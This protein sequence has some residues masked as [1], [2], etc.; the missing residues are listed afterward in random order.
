LRRIATELARIAGLAAALIAA[1]VMILR[2]ASLETVLVRSAAAGGLVFL[3]AWMAAGWA[4]RTLMEIVVRS[5]TET[6]RAQ[7]REG[8]PEDREAGE[9]VS[10]MR[11]AA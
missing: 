5:E 9:D 2:D 10:E 6:L 1:V 8:T 3:L 4:G 11:K 7:P